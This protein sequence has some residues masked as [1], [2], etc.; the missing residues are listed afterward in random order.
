MDRLYQDLARFKVP[1]G[2]RG[3]PD[4]VVALWQ[5]I[6]ATLFA[7]SPPTAYSWRR[8]ILRLFGARVGRGVL[9]GQSAR[10]TYPWKASFG[11]YSRIGDHVEIYSLAPIS[12][13][14][15][16]VVSNKSYLCAGTHDHSELTFPLIGRAIKI[17]D[18]AWI[19]IDCYIA[20][21]V[22]I[23]QGAV[24]ASRSTVIHDTDPAMM[25]AGGPTRPSNV[26]VL[27]RHGDGQ[28]SRRLATPADRFSL[29][30]HELTS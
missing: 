16:V 28:L 18:E 9:V 27:S 19:G 15:N 8:W 17:G 14:R 30:A 7:W 2:F 26:M 29:Q 11:D 23:G 21:G 1:S 13:G 4:V 25:A 24:I 6:Q 12:I 22:S 5:L 10:V 20:P 3:R